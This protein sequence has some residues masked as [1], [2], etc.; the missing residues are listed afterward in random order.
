MG[1]LL[2]GGPDEVPER[3]DAVSPARRL[4]LGVPVLLVH[5]ELDDDVPVHISREFAAAAGCE[6]AV[7]ADEGHYE[8]LDPG[9][10]AWRAVLDW[11]ARQPAL[12]AA[13]ARDG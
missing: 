2:G 6:L 4:P 13:E 1:E 3:Y 11:L 5:G 12:G 9:S 10:K 8:H 7:F